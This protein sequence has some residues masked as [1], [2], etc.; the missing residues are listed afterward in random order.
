M[1]GSLI[2]SLHGYGTQ[3]GGVPDRPFDGLGVAAVLLQCLPR[4]ARRRWPLLCLT[5]VV[6]GFA[7][8]QLRGYHLF[9]GTGL[10]IAVLS[11][12]AH[13]ERH[14]L[15]AMIAFSAAYVP[16]A[17]ALFALGEGESPA[18]FATFYV[19]LALIWAPDRGCA[20]PAPP[21]PSA[22]AASPRRPAPPNAPASP[23][24]CTTWSPTTSPRWWSRPRRPATSPPRPSA[25]KRPWARSPTPGGAPS[26]T[27]ATCS[28]CS[29]PTTAPMRG[30]RPSGGF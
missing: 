11:A 30:S 8:D 24:N 13:L 2:P 9:A 15:A 7:L 21:R 17:V 26:P 6:G 12:G 1:G 28:T 16:L 19:A 5:L 3:V 23:A 10:A 20:P 4:A 25:W 22:A 18:E 29:T 14:R 27:C